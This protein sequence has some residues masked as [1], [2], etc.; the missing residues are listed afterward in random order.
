MSKDGWLQEQ[1][2][3][4]VRTYEQW[5]E[6]MKTQ[7]RFVEPSVQQPAQQSQGTKQAP[8]ADTAG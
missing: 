5:P 3:K 2:D 4:A 8:R 7:A 6:W 1:L